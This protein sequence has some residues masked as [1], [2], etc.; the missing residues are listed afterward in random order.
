MKFVYKVSE[1]INFLQLSL[2]TKD[3]RFI[4]M[5]GIF[6]LAW[7]T[8]SA[9]EICTKRPEVVAI[10]YPHWHNYDHGSAWKGEGW[11]EWE[12][13]KVAIPRFP[14]HQQP[15]KPAADDCK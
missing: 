13:V 5:L 15:K 8:I 2:M 10:Y 1:K 3:T 12:G 7:S 14:G 9:Q 11:T 6:C 4:V